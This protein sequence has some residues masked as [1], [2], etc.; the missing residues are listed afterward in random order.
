M[1]FK[2]NY[3][4]GYFIF[5]NLD[6]EDKIRMAQLNRNNDMY[7]YIH[8][9]YEKANAINFKVG[10]PEQTES[11]QFYF[12]VEDTFVKCDSNRIRIKH[13]CLLIDSLVA[14][15]C[16]DIELLYHAHLELT[17]LYISDDEKMHVCI[18]RS[19][20]GILAVR[21]KFKYLVS[22]ENYDG[23]KS[24]IK[25]FIPPLLIHLKYDTLCNV[26]N[27]QLSE[28]STVYYIPYINAILCED[29]GNDFLN[30]NFTTISTT[31]DKDLF[32]CRN[33]VFYIREHYKNKIINN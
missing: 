13:I 14:N 20:N 17:R 5:I 32:V 21:T 29:C 24:Y 22:D 16:K 2:I 1:N 8:K 28:D 30:Q 19:P 31:P 9:F 25:S 33:I 6:E 4:N 15:D 23:I 10:L 11:G 26:C 18:V 7:F 12:P 3:N 27:E